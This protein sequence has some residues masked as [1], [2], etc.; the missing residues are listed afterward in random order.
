MHRS[1]LVFTLALV[2]L[3]TA[4]VSMTSCGGGSGGGSNPDLVLLG[5]NVPN[6]S[7]IPLNQALIF[8]FSANINPATI[9]PDSLRVVGTTGPFFESTVVDGN[10]VA[11]IPTVP[12]FADYSDA[13][14]APDTEYTVSLT[15]FPAVTTIETTTG[16]PLLS[17]AS[18][19]FRTLP[20]PSPDIISNVRC[21][22]PDG[23]L[24]TADDT[25]P[26]SASFFVEPRRAIRHGTP[27]SLGG[28]S[29]DEGCLQNSANPLYQPP[30]SDPSAIQA[31]SGPGARLLCMQNEGSPRVVPTLSTPTHNQPA[32]G[33]PSATNPGLIDLPAIRVKVNEPLDPLTIEPFFNGTPVNVQ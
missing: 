26:A 30:L 2:I 3:L 29:D 15:E 10:L 12:A 6:L 21:N 8:T 1:R 25:T 32:V 5:F 20:A 31:G 13:G 23:I 11:L 16:K 18:F 19:T 14:Y 24:G 27:P 28:L 4:S 17:S 7:G 9:T 22:G 33:S